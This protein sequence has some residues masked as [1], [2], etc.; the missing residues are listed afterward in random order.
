MRKKI[1]KSSLF[2]YFRIN[3]ANCVQE[4]LPVHY[5]YRLLYKK[6]YF[7]FKAPIISPFLPIGVR[8]NIYLIKYIYIYIYLYL[9][10]PMQVLQ[11]Q[12][13]LL[14]IHKKMSV[15][16]LFTGLFTLCVNFICWMRRLNEEKWWKLV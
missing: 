16:A 4:V 8:N 14:N 7:L 1:R 2:R 5:R 13:Y 15:I 12:F 11:L 6:T 9:L 10:K 3:S